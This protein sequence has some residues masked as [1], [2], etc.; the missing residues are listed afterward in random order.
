MSRTGALSLLRDRF[1]FES[2]RPGQE[3][4]L[5]SLLSGRHTL[6]VMPTGACKSLI[7]QMAALL[8]PGTTLVISPLIA[9]MKDQLDGLAAH[10]VPATLINSTVT[11]AE[12]QLRL[13]AM[14]RG[15]YRLVY[16][17]PER[18]RSRAFRDAL[19]DVSVGLLA[20]DEAHC[21]SQWGHDFRPDYMH[22]G[23][24]RESMGGPVTAALTATATPQVQNDIV[25]RL[26]LGDAERVVTGFNRPNLAF[27][28]HYTTSDADKLRSLQDLVGQEAGAGIVYVGTRRDAEE[29]AQ[30]AREVLKV[31]TRH[32]HA[33]LPTEERTAV[34][35][36]F[37]SGKLPLVVATNAFG[38]GIDR[39]DLRF[40]I[41]Y[42]LPGTLEAYYQ[43]AGRAGR[44]GKPA[45]CTLLYS[46]KD[47]AL[48]EWFIENAAPSQV[49][50]Q[51]LH[52]I[53]VRMAGQAGGGAAFV[54]LEN[55][56]QAS[57]LYQVK[58][59]L[60][61]SQLEEVGALQRL[62]D[63]GTGLWVQVGKLRQKQLDAAVADT[64]ARRDHRRRQLER[65]IA[66]AE[67]DTCRRRVILTHFGDRGPAEVDRCCDIC[68]SRTQASSDTRCAE[69]QAEQA[70][71]DVLR[72]VADLR[73]DVG[74][75]LLAKILKGSQAKA[76]KRA[77]YHR[78]HSHGLLAGLRL[79]DIVELIDHLLRL[80]YLKAVGGDRP[81]VQLAARGRQ[82]LKANAAIP[83]RL[84]HPPRP[85]EGDRRRTGSTPVAAGPSQIPSQGDEN[86]FEALRSWRLDRAREL[87]GPAFCVFA[88]QTLREI[89][90]RRPA[91]LEQLLAIKGVGPAKLGQYGAAVLEVVKKSPAL[92][93]EHHGAPSEPVQYLSTAPAASPQTESEVVELILACVK[94]LAYRLPRSGVAKL[95]VGSPSQRTAAYRGYRL[96]GSLNSRGRGEVL[97]VVDRLLDNGSLVSDSRGHL[98]IAP[99]AQ[100][101][102]SMYPATPRGADADAVEAFL[103]RPHSRDLK[104]PWAAGLALDFHSRFSGDRWSRSETGELAYRFKYCGERDLAEELARRLAEG[105]SAHPD[106]LPADAILPVP[107]SP[108]ERAFQPV[109]VLAVALG[110]VVGVPV[111]SD[112]LVKVRPTRPQKEMTNLAQKRANVRGAFAVRGVE[113]VRGKRLLVL[114]DLVDSGVTMTEV[115]RVLTRAGALRVAVLALTKTIHGE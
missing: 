38:M 111:L 26:D 98:A 31:S 85:G 4:A 37:I 41:H 66:Y 110:R 61:L 28:V 21:I 75:M 34:Q 113:A 84:E 102:S 35:D 100:P 107:P 89:A 11:R 51:S 112:V 3:E 97:A 5:E 14:A 46:P 27:H 52:V 78:L 43:E 82:A 71:L 93:R 10:E 79:T 39:A 76:L 68:E 56:A 58:L 15:K 8:R 18:L 17:A 80:G 42:A 29:V 45:L 92:S 69:S 20:V 73:W 49:E 55:L 47:R 70:A 60:A 2:F 12:Q 65:M 64:A 95:L 16:V 87:G 13:H 1:G 108:G 23:P 32:Y 83:V 33:G 94:D 90:R 30:F 81:L 53:L 86:L 105:L 63:D 91:S 54:N 77:D 103:S 74:R 9:L 25:R 57:G 62:G 101:P 48:Q 50:V 22:I 114:D 36:A 88:D 24:A 6:V 99:P 44:D 104:G 19:A 106:L 7:Y 67:G 72:A 109:P 40:V 59:R 96:Y 115:L